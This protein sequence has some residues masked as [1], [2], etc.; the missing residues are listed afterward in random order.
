MY[1]RIFLILTFLVF[2]QFSFSCSKSGSN[3]EKIANALANRLT[4]SLDFSGGSLV[5][6][7]KPEASDSAQAPQIDSVTAPA[8]IHPGVAFTVRLKTNYDKPEELDKA[9]VHVIGSTKHLVVDAPLTPLEGG[10]KMTLNGVLNEDIQLLGGTFQLEYALQNKDGVTGLYKQRELTVPDEEE[11]PD[12]PTGPCCN[13]GL[14]VDAEDICLEEDDYAC[15]QDLCNGEHTCEATLSDGYCLIEETCYEED[16]KQPDND[17]LSCLPDESTS[18]WTAVAD[19]TECSSGLDIGTGECQNGVCEGSDSF[20]NKVL[21][22]SVSPDEAEEVTGEPPAGT[23]DEATAP[24]ILSVSAPDTLHLGADYKILLFYKYTGESTI[25]SVLMH[26]EGAEN[27][28]EIPARINET[29]PPHVAVTGS[30]AKVD[31]IPDK[32]YTFEFALTTENG[33]V[34]GHEQVTIPIVEETKECQ[35]EV[36]CNG[37]SWVSTGGYCSDNDPCTYGDACNDAHECKGTEIVCEND[38]ETCGIQRSCNGTDTCTERYPTTET[39]CDDG[40]PCTYNDDCNGSGGCGGIEIVCEND[41][42]TCGIQRSCNGTDACEESYPGEE[43]SCDDANACT[44]SDVCD[45]SGNCGGTEIVCEN[46]AETCGIQRACNGTDACEES[47][48]GEETSCDDVNACTYSDVCNGSGNCG[49]TEIVCENAAETCGI[50]RSCNGTDACEE[51]YPGEETSCDDANACT[52][53]DVCDG[54]GGCGGTEIICENDA[55]TCGIQRACNGTDACEESYPGEETSCDDANACTYSDVC[56]GSGGCGG[57]EIICENDAETC[58]IQRA[59]NGTD[60]CDESYPGEETSCDDA[61]ACTY[62]DVCDGSGGCGGTEIICENDAETCGIQRSCNGTDACEESY[63]G[64]ETSCDDANACTYS[65][66]CDGSGNCGGTEIVCENDAET[67]GIQ[68]ACNGTDACDESYPGEETSCDD[69]LNCTFSDVCDG[70]GNCG[71]Q[72]VACGDHASC[73]ETD[74][75]C[76]CENDYFP[77]PDSDPPA[78]ASPCDP[79]PC[80]GEHMTCSPISLGTYECGC[81]EPYVY[82]E[83]EFLCAEPEAAQNDTREQASTVQNLPA[84]IKASIDTS[85]DEDWFRLDY[86]SRAR[87]LEQLLK[88]TTISWEG[89]LTD[90]QIEIY[91]SDAET[92]L[93]ARNDD[94]GEDGFSVLYYPANA[95]TYYIRITG[96]PVDAGSSYLLRI[97]TVEGCYADENCQDGIACNGWELCVDHQCT[98]GTSMDCGAGSCLEPYGECA[99]NE[100]AW[101]ENGVC[102][103]GEC[104]LDSDCTDD[105]ECTVDSCEQGVCYHRPNNATCSDGQFCNGVEICDISIGCQPGQPPT[106]PFYS[107]SGCAKLECDE[108]TDK[109]FLVG[110]DESCQDG[111]YCNGVEYCKTSQNFSVYGFYGSGSC[112]QGAEP[113]VSDGVDCTW[114]DCN[115]GEDLTDNLGEITHNPADYNCN[116]GN[117]CTVDTCGLDGCSFDCVDNDEPCGNEIDGTCQ[118]CACVTGCRDDSNCNDGDD[119]T[120]DTCNTETGTCEYERWDCDDDDPCTFDYCE[121]GSCYYDDVADGVACDDGYPCTINDRCQ[122][123]YC[124]GDYIDCDA[125]LGTQ[126]NINCLYSHCVEGECESVPSNEGGYCATEDTGYR[127]GVC[128]NGVCNPTQAVEPYELQDCT[129]QIVFMDSALENLVRE[130]AN[131]YNRDLLSSD[132]EHITALTSPGFPSVTIT[133]LGG[134]EC[135]TNLETLDLPYFYSENLYST[136][137]YLESEEMDMLDPSLFIKDL[138]PLQTLTKLKHLNLSYQIWVNDLVPLAG[139]ENLESLM[140]DNTGV[141][142]LYPLAG[143]ES[144]KTLL[145]SKWLRNMGE[146][147]Y[148]Q[149]GTVCDISPLVGLTKLETLQLPYNSIADL[150]ALSNML[151]LQTIGLSFNRIED[152]APLLNNEE[153]GPGVALDLS[154]N[155]FDCD[156]Q[157]LE[158]NELYARGAKLTLTCETY[159][160][161]D[162]YYYDLS[163]GEVIDFHD[164]WIDGQ[165]LW[166]TYGC[167]LEEYHGP[168]MVYRYKVQDNGTAT[169]TFEHLPELEGYTAMIL[170]DCNPYRCH[171]VANGFT[172]EMSVEYGD[173]Y[174]LV[175]ES[176]AGGL[177]TGGDEYGGQAVVV[178]SSA[179][180]GDLE[181]EDEQEEE[182]EAEA[183][184][185]EQEEEEPYVA[186]YTV[187]LECEQSGL[188]GDTCANPILLEPVEGETLRVEGDTRNFEDKYANCSF[189]PGAPDVYYRFDLDKP[190]AVSLLLPEHEGHFSVALLKL[191]DDEER[192]CAQAT[193]VLDENYG[194]MYYAMPSVNAG[195]DFLYWLTLSEGVTTV[196][197]KFDLEAGSYVVIVDGLG[198][199]IDFTDSA[200]IVRWA[201]TSET[202]YGFFGAMAELSYYGWDYTSSVFADLSASQGA[203]AL[204]IT[205]EDV[206]TLRDCNDDNSC[207]EDTCNPETGVCDNTPVEDGT[208]YQEMDACI[209]YVCLEGQQTT[210]VAEDG[211]DCESDDNPCTAGVCLS[212]VCEEEAVTESLDCNDG[213]ACTT[214]DACVNGICVGQA[215]TDCNDGLFCTDDTCLDSNAFVRVEGEFEDIRETGI[216]LH[217]GL[218]E[219]G[220][221]LKVGGPVQLDFD[222]PFYD[223]EIKHEV[224]I[225]TDGVLLFSLDFEPEDYYYSSSYHC[226]EDHRYLDFIAP[227]WAELYNESASKLYYAIT[228][229]GDERRL[230]VQWTNFKYYYSYYHPL[231]MQAALYADGRIEFRYKDLDSYQGLNTAVI[232]MVS[233][234][235]YSQFVQ[236]A[237]DEQVMIEE[238]MVLRYDTSSPY[239]CHHDLAASGGC[240]VD[241]VC[242]AEEDPCDDGDPCTSVDTCQQGICAGEAYSC[243][244]ENDCTEDVCDGTGNCSNNEVADETSCTDDDNPC[245]LDQC[246]SGICTHDS[247]A[248]DTVCAYPNDPCMVGLCTQGYCDTY[249]APEGTPCDDDGNL[250]TTDACYS[251]GCEH[252]PAPDGTIC[253][254]DLDPCT[255]DIC[256]DGICSHEDVDCDDGNSCTEDFCGGKGDCQYTELPNGEFCT[257][258]ASVDGDEEEE[259]EATFV[260]GQC[261][262]GVC[263]ESYV[264]QDCVDE[265]RFADA[266]LEVVVRE[267]LEQPEGPLMATDLA[268]ISTLTAENR[269][270]HYLVGMECLT[271]LQELNLYFNQIENLAPIAGLTNLGLLDVSRNRLTDL[272]PITGLVNLTHLYLSFNEIVNLDALAT[273]VSLEWLSAN[274][275]HIE[276][277]EVL[278]FMPDLKGLTLYGNR[279][280]NISP[281]TDISGLE[282]LDLSYNPVTDVSVLSEMTRLHSLYL[283]GNEIADA[284]DLSTLTGLVR[285]DLG[286]NPLTNLAFLQGSTQLDFLNLGVHAGGGSSAAVGIDHA[287]HAVSVE[288]QCHRHLAV[289]Q[290]RR[291]DPSGPLHQ[292][293]FRCYR[294]AKPR[295]AGISQPGWKQARR[296]HGL[297]TI[298]RLGIAESARQPDLRP[299]S[300]GGKLWSGHGR[301]AQSVVESLRLQTTRLFPASLVETG[302][303][304]RYLL[305]VRRLP[306]GFRHH[307]RRNFIGQHRHGRTLEARLLPLRRSTFR[308]E[309]SGGCLHS[310]SS[311]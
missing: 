226:L 311:V 258:L 105:W 56:D 147:F 227:Y 210:G 303:D 309:R 148:L 201:E 188:L 153:F 35:S 33:R 235:D 232:G 69:E 285:L 299:L 156:G 271:G 145:V 36:C 277:I 174:C 43:T 31:G 284:S 242:Y 151:N 239:H 26:V 127:L 89:G 157:R 293:D 44:Y 88:I 73:T 106:H 249:D 77:V 51:S 64:T 237:C 131:V 80:T 67:C 240:L 65:D 38:E 122:Y 267:R 37:G 208:T 183:E 166:A 3:A 300:L 162:S 216:E 218:D 268:E 274:S 250:C 184:F 117:P 254:T 75:S 74:G 308:G 178:T 169:F 198:G 12:C 289:E 8:K 196:P 98:A 203:Y 130:Q 189:L 185:E 181:A 47:Y 87:S 119:C 261:W 118:E 34:G 236:Y 280:A 248:D 50:Q 263:Q 259:A 288:L 231:T 124:E 168:E 25:K 79:T 7:D 302:R 272:E 297:G 296:Y 247:L 233:T 17:C 22:E 283:R 186:P 138:T 306:G 238:G 211:I 100:C 278:S 187:T 209:T 112:Y 234:N 84:N 255:D 81:E 28:Y 16:T 244:D 200:A 125:Q 30:L 83:A 143:L 63:P 155:S 104:C 173:V 4:E 287:D 158:I 62:S 270:I 78:C 150:S 95:G 141:N 304:S 192:A 223:G 115:E 295:R 144:L 54:S 137:Y 123:G 180:D 257:V 107:V 176:P 135:L 279:V 163:C 152:L 120:T 116:D 114:D 262:W 53:S 48:P 68:R 177:I 266:N 172:F 298:A 60:A 59:C 29:T 194:C 13:G 21:H 24:Q 55:E 170:E 70:E 165:N 102:T 133:H 307:L 27:H 42:E 139:L 197:V 206:C 91:A 276:D 161:E 252:D 292:R 310:A 18:E 251:G 128:E 305:L 205:L 199:E 110:D 2:A 57:T 126:G 9:I 140:L 204:E 23:T 290:S 215:P 207:T 224:Y 109:V 282:Y 39:S 41:A 221:E 45:G 222:F 229:E 6:S 103:T 97:E 1:V 76:Q 301:H 275:N 286:N 291:T 136:L 113:D 182:Q 269:S 294:I 10:W 171:P 264:A 111:L 228:G 159:E 220:N 142:D 256:L 213:I 96:I 72:A 219:S 243:D 93:L 132:V 134:L 190:Q 61:N 11:E 212:G 202:G 92:L 46:D 273:M 121:D 94:G 49:G 108:E 146:S 85:A 129:S 52:Y 225:G 20:V 253:Q 246:F 154:S 191:G 15:T 193:T 40:N 66:V 214:N 71:G 265:V 241:G 217:F 86:N 260:E 99:C 164:P 14:W 58:G 281:L 230:I 19:G 82:N 101:M 32:S 179:V 5:D 195:F 160:R 167:D 90:T 245:T 175:V 149:L